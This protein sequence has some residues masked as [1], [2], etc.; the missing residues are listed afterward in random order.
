MTSEIEVNRL[1][2]D[3]AMNEK[4]IIDIDKKYRLHGWGYAPIV[5]TEG[6]GAT[7]KDIKGKEYI[8]FL[9][10]TAGVLGI[11]HS[12]P[13][14]VKAVKDQ[15][16]KISHVLT[17]FVTPTTAELAKKVAQIAPGKL[18][19]NCKSYFS[20]GGTEAN[21]TA[22]KFAMLAT[23]KT[24]V[25]AVYWGY[26]GGSLAMI[27]LSGQ[28]W[29]KAGLPKYPGFH[30]IPNAYCYRCYYGKKHHECDFECARALESC[31]LHA[32][33]KD[34]VAVFIQ[35]FIQGNGG[36]QLPW[37]PEYFKI[38]REICDKHNIIYVDD[39]VQTGMGRTG[40]IWA[41]DYFN[42]TPDIMSS[43]KA[44]GGGMPVAATTIRSDLIPADIAEGAW[45]IFTMGGSPVAT[46][47]GVAAIDVMLEEKLPEK[48]KRQGERI[49]ARLKE[50][51]SMHPLIGEVRG[52]GLMIGVELVKSKKTKE[53]ATE[54]AVKVWTKCLERGLFFGLNA[55]VPYG[56][57]VKF[58]PPLVLTDEQADKA[59]NIFEDTLKEVEKGL[60]KKS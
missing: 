52:P 54:E 7:F 3:R 41:A 18:K 8:D 5:V 43:A 34:N 11:G 50:M 58:K 55:K 25:I 31:V 19:N 44:L 22:I 26:H 24:E 23:K 1:F 39:E 15:V 36:H 40:K 51:E 9:A 46:A 10:Q 33:S 6:K 42:V 2:G 16:E 48:A 29:H 35:E 20:C 57:I 12:N 59:L 27:Q 60:S 17:S 32:C 49:T 13:K 37:S 38:I 45:H 30:H 14:Y 28:S 53:P 56:N 47:G 21:E 4:E